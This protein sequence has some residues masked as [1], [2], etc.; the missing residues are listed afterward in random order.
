MFEIIAIIAVVLDGFRPFES[1]QTAG[2][3]IPPQGDADSVAWLAH[4]PANLMAKLTRIFVDLDNR[5]GRAC[6]M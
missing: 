3:T 1:E 5:I 6:R 2:F 4:G